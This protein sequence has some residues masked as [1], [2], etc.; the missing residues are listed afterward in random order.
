M[1]T[2]SLCAW[3]FSRNATALPNFHP[4]IAW[5]VSRVFYSLHQ[6]R[7]LRELEMPRTLKETRK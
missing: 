4:L 7:P 2:A 3:T 1:G 6:L 5:A